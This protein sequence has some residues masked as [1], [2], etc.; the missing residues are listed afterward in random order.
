MSSNGEG[1]R[2]GKNSASPMKKSL[3]SEER[4]KKKADIDRVFSRGRRRKCHGARLVYRENG[5]SRNRFAVCP[6]RKYGGSV[7][8]N[9]AKR[10]CR[11]IFRDI[12]SDLKLGHDL[13]LVV[14]P[15]FDTLK[16]RR[17]QFLALTQRADLLV[18][19]GDSEPI[20]TASLFQL[21]VG[22]NAP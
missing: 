1:A 9:R 11:E 14:Y 2:A 19:V 16:E 5:L 18:D 4:L 10:I 21:N 7:P 12:K 22:E 20:A 13:V 8:R 15:G 17:D 3:T 6:V